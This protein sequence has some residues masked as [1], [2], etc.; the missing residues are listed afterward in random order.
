VQQEERWSLR[1]NESQY[2]HYYEIQTT[3][4]SLTEN[5][6]NITGLDFFRINRT[7]VQLI[8]VTL[9]I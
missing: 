5:K 4:I 2:A 6:S 7:L 1:E 8:A 9:P 3:L